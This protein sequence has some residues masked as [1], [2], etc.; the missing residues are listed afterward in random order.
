VEAVDLDARVERA[1][2]RS[3]ASLFGELGE[4]AFRDLETAA[5]REA[6]DAERSHASRERGQVL[7]LGG[8]ILEREENR[9]LLRGRALVVWLKVTPE[10]A[11][12]RIGAAGA[13]SR[14]LV[15]GVPGAPVERLREILASRTEAYRAAADLVI[16]TEGRT[17][18][19]VAEAVAAAWEAWR[20]WG[21]SAS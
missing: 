16:D 7:A 18:A 9:A 17:E 3:V 2:G 13:S 12:R 20:G 5:L 4:G 11:A 15:G 14:P 19:E 6:L 21:S 1:A 8:G 10:T